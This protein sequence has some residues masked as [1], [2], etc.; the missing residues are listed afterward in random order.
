MALKEKII[1]AAIMIVLQACVLS[2]GNDDAVEA[3]S[4]ETETVSNNTIEQDQNVMTEEEKIRYGCEVLADGMYFGSDEARAELYYNIFLGNIERVMLDGVPRDDYF[5]NVIYTESVTIA[6]YK[7][8]AVRYYKNVV[9]NIAIFEDEEEGEKYI[10]EYTEYVNANFK[11]LVER[12]TVRYAKDFCS[13]QLGYVEGWY[14]EDGKEYSEE[15][16]KKVIRNMLEF[17]L[18]PTDSDGI[19]R[20]IGMG[21][22]N[23]ESDRYQFI[24]RYKREVEA[25]IS[26]VDAYLDEIVDYSYERY[27]E[28]LKTQQTNDVLQASEIIE[29]NNSQ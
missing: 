2:T 16:Y 21:I 23:S 19:W 28:E 26:C 29:E 15:E 25:Y 9:P 5:D 12:D 1:S 4:Q 22:L 17:N 7:S 3:S 6:E 8:S 13:H 11:E 14:L 27:V 18:P 10:D 24:D 20:H